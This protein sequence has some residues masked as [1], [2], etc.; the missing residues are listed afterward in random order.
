MFD[1]ILNFKERPF[2]GALAD[3]GFQTGEPVE[4]KV[5]FKLAGF[6]FKRANKP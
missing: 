6:E 1:S 5:D 2:Q 3:R 4:I